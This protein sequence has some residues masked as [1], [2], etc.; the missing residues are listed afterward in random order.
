[1]SQIHKKEN[2]RIVP[3]EGYF[4][5]SQYMEHLRGFFRQVRARSCGIF[6]DNC[7]EFGFYSYVVGSP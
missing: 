1:M 2:E 6:V 5:Q 4:T 3:R 7:E